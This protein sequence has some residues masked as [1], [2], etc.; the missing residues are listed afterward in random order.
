[1]V[2]RLQHIGTFLHNEMGLSLRGIFPMCGPS[3]IHF[4]K[5]FFLRSIARWSQGS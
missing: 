4:Q 2:K 3:S 1:M 5:I